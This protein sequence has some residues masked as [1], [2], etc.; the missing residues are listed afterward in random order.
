M[1]STL[2]SL[3]SPF[4]DVATVNFG[5]NKVLFIFYICLASKNLPINY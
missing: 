1:I 4:Y 5:I 2:F 3:Q